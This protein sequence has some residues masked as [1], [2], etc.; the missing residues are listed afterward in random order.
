MVMAYHQLARQL[1]MLASMTNSTRLIDD[2]LN[3]GSRSE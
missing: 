2:K 1:W 3:L